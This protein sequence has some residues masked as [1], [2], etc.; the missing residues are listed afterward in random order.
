MKK[1]F[2]SL[3]VLTSG[4]LYSC[5]NTM[6]EQIDSTSQQPQAKISVIQTPAVVTTDV[7]ARVATL[8]NGQNA[9]TKSIKSI[10]EVIPLAG[11]DGNPALY[12]VNYADNQ[13]YAI[14]S[15]NPIPTHHC[16]Q[17]NGKL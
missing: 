13:G 9:Q 11:E 16:L 15:A 1:L 17:R 10:K 6:D 12:V 14:I 4:F 3:L 5:E 8:F 2:Y 7:A